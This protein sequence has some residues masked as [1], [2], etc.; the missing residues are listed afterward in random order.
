MLQ[1]FLQTLPDHRIEQNFVL[2]DGS[3]VEIKINGRTMLAIPFFFERDDSERI[4]PGQLPLIIKITI[5]G[6]DREFYV[7]DESG[8]LKR[9]E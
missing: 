1:E 6:V 5:E 2:T 9:K 8:F 4:L 3:T 7:V